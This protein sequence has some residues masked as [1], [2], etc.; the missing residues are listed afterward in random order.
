MPELAPAYEDAW[1]AWDASGDAKIWDVAVS[2]GLSEV[3]ECDVYNGVTLRT[4]LSR[5]S[6][7]PSV[8]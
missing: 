5:S 3:Q 8:L 6:D 1:T 7:G 2:D 4:V